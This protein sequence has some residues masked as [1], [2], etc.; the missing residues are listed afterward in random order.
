MFKKKTILHEYKTRMF[1]HSLSET[2]RV[3]I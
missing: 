1:P 2:L 3:T